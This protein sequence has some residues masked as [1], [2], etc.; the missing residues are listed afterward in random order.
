MRS[1]G[2][3][4]GASHLALSRRRFQLADHV[5]VSGADIKDGLL[6]IE[7]NRDLP[8]R[9]KPRMVQIGAR[10]TKENKTIAE[11]VTAK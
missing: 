5:E 6:F 1:A 3:S 2:S 8:Q 11:T 4:T 9:L 7:L 10:A